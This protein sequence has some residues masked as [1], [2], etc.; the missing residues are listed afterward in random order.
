M[1]LLAPLPQF[2]HYAELLRECMCV[3]VCVYCCNGDRNKIILPFHFPSLYA[4]RED[5]ADI[6][7]VRGCIHAV[8]LWMGDNIGATVGICCAVG[9]PQVV[10]IVLS[11]NSNVHFSP[12]SLKCSVVGCG[13]CK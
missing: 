6:I 1:A 2:H 12:N 7:H 11:Y 9:L 4:Q 13:Q 5:L 3:N 10:K 8:N